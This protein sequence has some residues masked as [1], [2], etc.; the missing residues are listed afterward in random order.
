MPRNQKKLNN[1][2]FVAQNAGWNVYPKTTLYAY[3]LKN[4]INEMSDIWPAKILSIERSAYY[5]PY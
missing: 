4:F 3:M 2:R 1:W 5:Y